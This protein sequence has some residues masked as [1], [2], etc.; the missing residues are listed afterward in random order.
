MC[1][2]PLNLK[3]NNQLISQFREYLELERHYSFYTVENYLR[4]INQFNNFLAKTSERNLA[5]VDTPDV[6]SF[7]AY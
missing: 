5:E 1:P 4:V 3:I 6:A 7:L 2:S